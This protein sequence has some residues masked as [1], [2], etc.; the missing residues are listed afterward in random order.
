[1]GVR[2]VW[3]RNGVGLGLIWNGTPPSL[4]ASPYPPSPDSHGC[5]DDVTA[6]TSEPDRDVTPHPVTLR[7]PPPDDVSSHNYGVVPPVERGEGELYGGTAAPDVVGGADVPGGAAETQQ[8]GLRGSSAPRSRRPPRCWRYRRGGSGP[9]WLRT[10]PAS[11]GVRE[12][13]RF[14]PPPPCPSR[15]AARGPA[16]P[17]GWREG[18]WGGEAAGS[19]VPLGPNGAGTPMRTRGRVCGPPAGWRFYGGAVGNRAHPRGDPTCGAGSRSRQFGPGEPQGRPLPLP[20]HSPRV[21]SPFLASALSAG[22]GPTPQPG[23]A[24]TAM[25]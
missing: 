2:W 5:S 13:C 21:S 20:P 15:P 8:G 4:S 10:D 25:H 14:P 11:P 1:M 19:A 22:A 24:R 23:R 18:G 12:G 16:Q 17:G 3:N 6:L 9:W 7:P